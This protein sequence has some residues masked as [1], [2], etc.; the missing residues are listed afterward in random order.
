MDPQNA[1]MLIIGNVVL[2]LLWIVSEL[3]GMSKCEYNGVI[4]FVIS[5]C[6]CLGGKK[7]YLDIEVRHDEAVVTVNGRPPVTVAIGEP[8]DE[9][10]RLEEP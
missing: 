1:Q 10:V 3:M 9:V 5:G 6:S 4:Q 7:I 2:G 8:I